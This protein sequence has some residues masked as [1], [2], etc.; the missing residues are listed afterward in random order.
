MKN[1]IFI[2]TIIL[3]VTTSKTQAQNDTI[4]YWKSG[5]LIDKQSIKPADLDSIT[6]RR[7]RGPI[8]QHYQGG[9]IAYI[10]KVGE[11][12]YIAGEQHGL[13]AAIVD[14]SSNAK[15]WNGTIT[16]TGATA[17]ALGTGLSNTNLIIASQGNTGTYAA[18][19]CRDY[20]GGGYTDWFLP[21]KDELHKLYQNRTLIGGFIDSS[22]W[23]STEYTSNYGHALVQSFY[24]GSTLDLNKDYTSAVRAIRRF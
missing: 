14:Q 9:V 19:L 15:W 6:F 18:K 4:F 13:I 1:I 7:P 17:T 22:Y 3:L 11:P 12:G 10:F 20:H 2:L 16:T 5:F 24:N 8:G 23:S 21:S